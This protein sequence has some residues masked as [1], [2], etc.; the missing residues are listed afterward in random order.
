[1]KKTDQTSYELH[2][3][4]LYC[5]RVRWGNYQY[6]GF[7]AWRHQECYPGSANWREYYQKLSPNERTSAAQHLFEI[8]K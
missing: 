2:E 4:C 5:E 6:L 8:S 1:M 3:T 7:G